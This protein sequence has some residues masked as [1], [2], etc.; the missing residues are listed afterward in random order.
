[1]RELWRLSAPSHREWLVPV[2]LLSPLS[3]ADGDGQVILTEVTG[4]GM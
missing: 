4:M 1:M 2:S 3:E